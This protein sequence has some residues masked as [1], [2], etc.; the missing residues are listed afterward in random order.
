[1]VKCGSTLS[2]KPAQIIKYAVKNMGVK[3]T[4]VVFIWDK[5]PNVKTK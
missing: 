3:T 5:L 1:M 2:H 4:V